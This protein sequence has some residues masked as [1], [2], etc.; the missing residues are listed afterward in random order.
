MKNILYAL[1]ILSIFSCNNKPKE[2]TTTIVTPANG[3]NGMKATTAVESPVLIFNPPHGKPGHDC[4]IAEGAPLNGAKKAVAQV[5]PTKTVT[6]TPVT[7]PVVGN[8]PKAGKLNPAHGETGHRCDIAVGAPLNSKPTVQVQPAIKPSVETKTME[9]KTQP[10][11]TDSKLNPAHGE[12]G[13]RCDI[14]VGA[15]LT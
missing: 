8:N 5:A 11:K 15:P 6:T 10:V 3:A 12:A 1:A 9:V 14:A 7:Q 13:H 4:A 2:N